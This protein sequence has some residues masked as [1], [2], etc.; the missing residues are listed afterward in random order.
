ML[1]P[2]PCGHPLKRGRPT[3]RKFFAALRSRRFARPPSPFRGRGSLGARGVQHTAKKPKRKPK[4]TPPENPTKTRGTFGW[5]TSRDAPA[6]TS[7]HAFAL[8]SQGITRHCAQD[9]PRAPSRVGI[10]GSC[11][12]RWFPY[13]IRTQ[14]RWGTTIPWRTKPT[15]SSRRKRLL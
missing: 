5:L 10:Y 11:R 8:L 2:P 1:K 12:S 6:G 15:S 14:G 7:L 4:T 3:G 9:A 13:S